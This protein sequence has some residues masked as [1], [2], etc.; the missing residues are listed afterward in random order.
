MVLRQASAQRGQSR[1]SFMRCF[2]SDWE[3]AHNA[4]R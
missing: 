1:V 3:A 4:V 2:V